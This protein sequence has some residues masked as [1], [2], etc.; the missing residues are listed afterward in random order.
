MAR[1]AVFLKHSCTSTMTK[2][3]TGHISFRQALLRLTHATTASCDEIAGDGVS[4]IETSWQ[5]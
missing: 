4:P 5:A 1:L 3:L 2:A